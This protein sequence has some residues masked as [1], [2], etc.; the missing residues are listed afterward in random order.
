MAEQTELLGPD[1]L[2]RAAALI[3]DGRL[4]VF[5]TETVYGL[6]ADA[7]NREAVRLGFAAKQRP[8]DNPLI[9]HLGG[10]AGLSAVAEP[11]GALERALLQTF[12]PGPFTLVLPRAAGVVAEVSAG[13]AT[14]A[15]RVPLHETARRLI[16]LSGRPVAAPSANRSG[17][18]SPTDFA[19]ARA[20]M[21]GRVAAILDGGECRFGIESTVVRVDHEA[22]R[23]VVLRPGSV[24]VE[25]IGTALLELAAGPAEHGAGVPDD[26]SRE[27]AGWSEYGVSY[28]ASQ[29][30]APSGSEE[31]TAL[32]PG[33]RHAHYQPRAKVYTL[34]PNLREDCIP[35]DV[36]RRVGAMVL[37]PT[38]SWPE[39][40]TRFV[41]VFGNS[42]EYGRFLYRSFA[43]FDSVG[44]DAIIAEL[45]EA[46]G[47]GIA[48]R[49]RLIRAADGRRAP[50]R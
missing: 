3:R 10:L 31:R 6:G 50:C 36:G 18:P 34:P 25:M 44:C 15:V 19:A 22:R 7:G 43:W 1:E 12:A 46:H 5:P 40:D 32:S 23:V 17:E 20:A 24:T 27:R 8:P 26:D 38:P 39:L 41:R 45:P 13:L 30:N 33:T 49:D 21:E 14:V 28:S 16:A 9:V 47:V 2:E 29:G 42:E 37:A 11:V 4:V 35:A 48:V